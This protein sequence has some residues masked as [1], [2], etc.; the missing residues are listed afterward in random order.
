[1]DKEFVTFQAQIEMK[2]PISNKQLVQLWRTFSDFVYLLESHD[3][4]YVRH[5]MCLGLNVI[6]C[7][8]K[9]TE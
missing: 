4:G 8:P 2:P 5:Q 6:Q 3:F 1:M 7:P 9:E